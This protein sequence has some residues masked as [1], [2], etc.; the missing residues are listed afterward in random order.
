MRRLPIFLALLATAAPVPAAAVEIAAQIF[1]VTYREAGEERVGEDARVPYLPGNACYTWYLRAEPARS[2]FTVVERLILPQ[3][4]DWG[5]TGTVPDD[6][7]RIEDGGIV[8]VTTMPTATDASG[9]FNHGW[10]VAEG[11][12]LG[13]HTIQLA[14]DD[15]EVARFKFEVVSPREYGIPATFIHRPSNR[16]VNDSW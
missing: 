9:W 12:P 7:T 15:A 16:S 8:A 10:C 3:A 2:G 4:V 1:Q 6:P 14:I 13:P 11:D 5:T